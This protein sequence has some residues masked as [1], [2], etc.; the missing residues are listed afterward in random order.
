MLVVTAGVL[1]ALVA[2]ALTALSG[3]DAYALL[4]LPDPGPVTKYGLPVVRVLAETGAVVCIGSLLLASF[5]IPAQRGGSL[6]A[7]GYAAV[8]TAGWAAAVWFAGAALMVPFLAADATGRGVSEVL[9]ADVLFGLLDALEEVKAWGLSAL[10][11][12]VVAL[13]C[14]IVLSW[15]WTTVAFGAALLGLFPVIATGHSASG[16]AHDMAT[17]SLL[18]HLFG[19]TLWVGGL[20]ALLAHGARGGAHLPLVARRFSRIALA[21]WIAMALSGVVNS[22][23]RVTPEQLVTT[24]YGV[25]VLV[26]VVALVALGAFGYAQRSKVVQRLAGGAGRGALL[27]LGA[28]EVL[29]MFATIGVA[30]ALGRTPPPAESGPT[31]GRTELLIGYPLPE[32]PDA[33][34]LLFTGRFDLVWGTLA[35]ALAVF[36]L[37][38]VRRLRARGDAWPVGRTAAWLLGCLTILAATS[39]GI[40]R[41]APA[42]F[43]VHMGQHMLL[44][45]LAPVFLVLAGPTSLALRVFKPAGKE[46]P[47]GARE[48]L[49]AFLH[50]PITRVLTN[51]FVALGLFVGSFYALYFSGLFDLALPQHWAHIAMNAHFLLVGYVF[52][53]PVIGIDPAPRQ[54]PSMGKLGLV[55]ASMPFHAFFGVVLMMSQNVIGENF[56]RSLDLPWMTDLLA[57]QQLGGGLAWASGEVPLVVV[58]LAL[59]IQWS[60]ADYRA[61]RRIDRKADADGE[62]DLAAYNEM[63]RRLAGNDGSAAGGS[64]AGGSSAEDSGAAG[65]GAADSGAGDVRAT[66]SSAEA[67]GEEGARED[68]SAGTD[69]GN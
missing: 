31:P 42:V 50:S 57:D 60:R 15:G 46:H 30:V 21:A 13:L 66:G 20:V 4:G 56:Y 43:S 63:L 12:F 34:N 36:Y 67:P 69:R 55:F 64:G 52:Y 24:T 14:R 40:G 3:S 65:S 1:A 9:S 38:G 18:F 39:S 25:L 62:A 44:S 37:L 59:L 54:L 22:L 51:P 27:R 45:M 58:M 47:P 32:P 61:A 6:T 29:T 19:A 16:G 7:D 8:R 2:A 26:K 33:L 35:L 49:L 48:W 17:N 68:S 11:V 41:Y 23:V 28:V 53:W 10:I 5:G